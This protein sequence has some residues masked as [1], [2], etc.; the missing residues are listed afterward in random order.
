VCWT[1]SHRNPG[2]VESRVA[3]SATWAPTVAVRRPR[4]GTS[5]YLHRAALVDLVAG[6]RYEYRVS[7]DDGHP[8]AWSSTFLTRAPA[9]GPEARVEAVFVCDVGIAGRHDHTCD[10][11]AAVI[12]AIGRRPPDVVLGGGDYAYAHGDPR[13]SDPA[14]AIGAWFDQMQ[15]LLAVVPFMPQLGNHE[16]EVGERLGDWR[17]RLPDRVGS[18]SGLSYSFD[19]GPAHF[20]GLHAPGRAPSE[21]DLAWLERDLR[22]A[23]ARGASWRIVFQ[24]AP[25][26]SH[27][28]SHPARAELTALAPRFAELGVDLHLSGHDQSYE[29]TH[30]LAA[31][32]TVHLPPG[33][34]GDTGDTGDTVYTAGAGVLFVKA[35]P[36]GKLSDRGRRFSRLPDVPTPPVVRQHDTG[37]HWARLTIDADVLEIAI[38]TLPADGGDAPA[39][40][41]RVRIVRADAARN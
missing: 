26:F 38:E 27:G 24:H 7:H 11:T 8:E 29:R 20:V 21:A 37:H 30:Q 28:T 41:D 10:D 3:G 36:A 40:V 15:P 12:D 32:G 35:S 6:E 23:A 39:V 17:P 31:D 13:F 16:V 33:V 1:G 34:T 25:V 2:V 14:D 19:L 4:P 9:D 18:A 5:G 22:A